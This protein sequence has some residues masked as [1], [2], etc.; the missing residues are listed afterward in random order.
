MARDLG[1]AAK[2][3]IEAAKQARPRPRAPLVA[4]NI[5][6]TLCLLFA[7]WLLG[8]TVRLPAR[9]SPGRPPLAGPWPSHE[10]LFVP[11]PTRVNPKEN[12]LNCNPMTNAQRVYSE[13]Q[14]LSEEER[15]ELDRLLVYVPDP[16]IEASWLKEAERRFDAHD[17]GQ[18]KSVPWAEARERIFAKP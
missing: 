16:E 9:P 1:R 7:R 5:M 11:T 17:A 13:I 10:G 15:D 6:G 3:R 2:A 18:M 4:L 8:I 14:N 12:M